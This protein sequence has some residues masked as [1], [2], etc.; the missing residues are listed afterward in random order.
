LD[1]NRRQQN[2][3]SP[4]SPVSCRLPSVFVVIRLVYS[5]AYRRHTGKLFDTI[6]YKIARGKLQ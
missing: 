5:L 4:F 3:L 1:L 2:T 6:S